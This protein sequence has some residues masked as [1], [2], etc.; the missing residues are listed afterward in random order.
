[1]FA[2]FMAQIASRQ[3]AMF[4][5]LKPTQLLAPVI[6]LMKGLTDR[7]WP[8]HGPDRRENLA[9]RSEYRATDDE[10]AAPATRGDRAQEA[11]FNDAHDGMAP[12]IS[13]IY[14]DRG[15]LYKSDDG[16]RKDST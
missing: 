3:G 11:L 6:G 2:N 13:A 14:D 7:T 16:V 9:H 12:E 4:L 10:F 8:T 5:K 15:E 1:V